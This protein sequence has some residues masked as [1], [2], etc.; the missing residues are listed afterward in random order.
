MTSGTPKIQGVHQ[1]FKEYTKKSAGTPKIQGVHQKLSRYTKKLL[2]TPKIIR[3]TKYVHQI[4]WCSWYTIIFWCTF[5]VYGPKMAV[6]QKIWC[7][8][9]TK[10]FRV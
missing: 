9:Y 8:I 4:I 3:Y 10:N 7:T 5:L 1:K 2:G 6:H